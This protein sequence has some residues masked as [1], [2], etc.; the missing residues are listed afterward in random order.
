MNAEVTIELRDAMLE[1]IGGTNTTVIATHLG[2]EVWPEGFECANG[3]APIF[4]EQCDGEI[5]VVVWADILQ[6]DPTHTIKLNGAK[7]ELRSDD[8]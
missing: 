1:L 6:E 8:E 7:T 2:I 4:I 3:G 5:R